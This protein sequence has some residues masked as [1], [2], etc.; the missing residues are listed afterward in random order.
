MRELWTIRRELELPALPG[1]AVVFSA[2][3]HPEEFC[4]RTANAGCGDCG[5]R[6]RGAIIID[7]RIGIDDAVRRGL[8]SMARECFVTTEKDLVR[9]TQAQRVRLE[10]TAPLFAAALTVRLLDSELAHGCAGGASAAAASRERIIGC[11]PTIIRKASTGCAFWW[12]DWA[13]WGMCC[14]RCRQWQRCARNCRSAMWA[15]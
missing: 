1:A 9:L 7:L 11:D 8:R 12:C 2:I 6:M 3:A 13:R 4:R 5:V 15:G 10:E 14:T